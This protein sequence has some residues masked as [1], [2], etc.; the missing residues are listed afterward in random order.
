MFYQSTA[1]YFSKTHSSP[2]KITHSHK[3]YNWTSSA[4]NFSSIR[5]VG[6]SPFTSSFYKAFLPVEMVFLIPGVDVINWKF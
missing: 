6:L 5:T 1:K 4:H 3:A 2:P